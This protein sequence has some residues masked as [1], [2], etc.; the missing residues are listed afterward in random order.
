MKWAFVAGGTGGHIY[1]AIAI[2]DYLRSNQL[3]Q[4]IVFLTTEKKLDQEIIKNAGYTFYPMSGSGFNQA[5]ILQKLKSLLGFAKIFFKSRHL[6]KKHQFDCVMGTGGYMSAPVL[7]AAHLA[8]KITA[9]LEPNVVVGLSNKWVSSFVNKVFFA[10]EESKKYLDKKNCVF[11]GNPIRQS[12]LNI[13]PPQNK[14]KK[15]CVMVFG[16]SQGAKQINDLLIEAMPHL[17]E[18]QE[19]VY[20]VHQTGKHGYEDVLKTYQKYNIEHEVHEYIYDIAKAYAQADIIIGRAGS[21]VL[22]IAACGRPSILI[23]Y[24]YA[25]D[26]HQQENAAVMEKNNAAYVLTGEKIDIHQFVSCLKDLIVNQEKR[27]ML[28]K[29]ALRLRH[30][31]AAQTIVNLLMQEGKHA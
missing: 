6:I 30:D 12:I 31:Q 10:F 18:N 22:E 20:F 5:G 15:I 25:A 13:A 9:T 4:D 29:G 17:D 14:T 1:P 2:A 7:W 19:Q 11:S 16:G 26:N 8:K 3:A 21:S 24:P 28:K 27:E 23:P